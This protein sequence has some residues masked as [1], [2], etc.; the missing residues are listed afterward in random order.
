MEIDDVDRT[1]SASEQAV[2][3]RE[4]PCPAPMQH[5]MRLYTKSSIEKIAEQQDAKRGVPPPPSQLL[6]RLTYD[7]IR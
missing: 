3:G 1:V 7:S 2:G 4:H 6:A 5:A